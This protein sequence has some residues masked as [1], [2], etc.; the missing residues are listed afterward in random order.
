MKRTNHLITLSNTYP[1]KQHSS[2]LLTWFLRQPTININAITHHKHSPLSLMAHYN[3]ARYL[4]RL[5]KHLDC[6][7]TLTQQEYNPLVIA[8]YRSS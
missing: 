3:N 1:Q 2:R 5:L 7:Q 6:D 4:K 8:V